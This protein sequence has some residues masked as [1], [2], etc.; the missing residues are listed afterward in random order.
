MMPIFMVSLGVAIV[1]M[2][3]GIGWAVYKDVLELMDSVHDTNNPRTAPG[4][5]DVPLQRVW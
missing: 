5:C 2:I 3:V 1:V 4:P